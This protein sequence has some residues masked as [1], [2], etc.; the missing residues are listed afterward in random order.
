MYE[1]LIRSVLTFGNESWSLKNKNRKIP[2]P[3]LKSAVKDLWI[4]EGKWYVEIR[5]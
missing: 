3:Q 2:N 4:S 5:V 1:T